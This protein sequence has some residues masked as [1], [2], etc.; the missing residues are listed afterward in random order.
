MIDPWNWF[1]DCQ[2]GEE[3]E[4][5]PGNIN[6]GDRPPAREKFASNIQRLERE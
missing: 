4:G 5:I 2:A 3:K 6:V 1:H